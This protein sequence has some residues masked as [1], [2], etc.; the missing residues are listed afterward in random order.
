MLQSISTFSSVG[1]AETG[2]LFLALTILI[3]LPATAQTMSVQNGGTVEVHNGGVWNLQG[4]T[5]DLGGAGSTASIAEISGGRFANGQLTAA[6]SLN[7]PSQATPAN[8]GIEISTSA[9]LGDV[10]VTRGHTVQTAQNGNE[11]IARFYDLSPTQNNSG[12]SATLTFSYSDAELNGRTESE[13]EFFKST[14]GGSTWSEEGFDS[15]DATANTVTLG[16]IASLSRWTLGSESAPLPVEMAAF[17]GTM[18][19][20]GVNLNWE[21]ASETNNAG[22]E[23]QRRRADASDKTSWKKI[24]FVD[25]T[26]TTTESQTYEFTDA[27]LPYAADTLSYRIRQVNLDGTGH[28]SE[29][30]RIERTVDGVELLGTYP[31]PAQSRATVRFAVPER[32][33][34]TLRLYDVLGQRVRTVANGPQEGR[35]ELP[36]GL[37]DLSS[38]IYFLQLTAE[39]NTRTRKLTVVR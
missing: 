19:D 29:P 4:T 34:V 11:S 14:D 2:I 25:G 23:I 13:L 22:F 35:T 12:L 3:S 21:T 5:V 16:G 37:S 31:N 28:V 20:R 33:N 18:S 1:K 8:L 27:D 6:R 26:G 30:I 24:G 39:G 32:Q 15:R 7:A 17:N 36:I 9:D 10:T 38:G